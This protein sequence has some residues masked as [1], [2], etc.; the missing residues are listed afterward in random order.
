MLTADVQSSAA[1]T[2]GQRYLLGISNGTGNSIAPTITG[3]FGVAGL[4]PENSATG[5]TVPATDTRWITFHAIGTALLLNTSAF[6]VY[7]ILLPID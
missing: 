3:T 5:F 6:P 7:W 1:T 2:P 4:F